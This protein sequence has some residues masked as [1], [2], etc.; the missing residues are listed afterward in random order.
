MPTVPTT[1]VPQVAPSG[2]GDIGQFAAP[3]VQPMENLAARQQEAFGRATEQAGLVA[4]RVGSAIQDDIDEATAKQ[5][6]VQ[7]LQA[8][9]QV[10]SEYSQL[11]GQDA[12]KGYEAAVG[13]L[14]EIAAK[15]MDGLQ[16]DTQRMMLEPS[17]AAT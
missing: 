8:F 6:D 9:S 13:R 1:F 14:G 5:G 3:G 4:F 16:N 11:L 10:E 15:A 2:G 12:D 17:S 7:S